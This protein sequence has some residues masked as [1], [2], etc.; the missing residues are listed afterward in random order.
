MFEVVD[1]R[2]EDCS[3]FLSDVPRDRGYVVAFDGAAT[4]NPHMVAHLAELIE[5]LHETA[6]TVDSW[7]HEG[8]YHVDPGTWVL[9]RGEALELGRARGG[10]SIFDLAEGRSIKR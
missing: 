5:D 9:D 3:R 8:W 2:V 6:D 7:Y 1:G 4:K 10:R